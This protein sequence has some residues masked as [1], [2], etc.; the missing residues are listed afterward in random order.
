MFWSGLRPI[1][2]RIYLDLTVLFLSTYGTIINDIHH[3]TTITFL[4]LA[5]ASTIQFLTAGLTRRW[6]ISFPLIILIILHIIHGIIASSISSIGTFSIWIFSCLVI[7]TSIILSVLFPAVDISHP[8]G[9]YNVGIVDFHLPVSFDIDKSK[10]YFH[11]LDTTDNNMNGFVS[12]RILYPTNHI[13]TNQK[14]G[15]RKIPYFNS[16]VKTVKEICKALMTVG[17]PPPL[18]KLTWMMDTWQLSSIQAQLNVQPITE[19]NDGDN[20]KLPMVIFS[21]GLTGNKFIYSYQGLNLASNGYF[22]AII[23]H[24]DGSAIGMTKYDGTFLPYD[25]SI[26]DIAKEC[27][28]KYVRARRQQTEHRSAELHAVTL[29]LLRMNESNIH[30]LDRLGISFV[31]R[32]DTSNVAIGG[33]SFGSASALTTAVRYPHLYSCVIAH[34]PALDWSCDDA[35]KVI[36]DEHRLKASNVQYNGGTGGYE[37]DNHN[38]ETSVAVEERKVSDSLTTITNYAENEINLHDKVDMLFLYSHEYYKKGWGGS[39]CTFAMHKHGQL[40]PR[41]NNCS[42]CVYIHHAQHS[43]FSDSCMMTPLWLARAIEFTGK[44]N[45]HETAQEIADRTIDFLERVARKKAIKLKLA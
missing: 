34:D 25:S 5:I 17:A 39:T 18:N 7:L 30:Q 15:N 8:K 33:H 45:P 27:D 4:S 2:S 37:H 21:H 28:V 16:N 23:D 9:K 12:V 26:Q 29:A 44:R 31:N 32:L 13:N 19:S 35:R 3:E 1:R 10:S 41:L 40:G 22:V 38:D 20:K 11:R 43:E 14:D 24:T 42:D 6:T 36:F